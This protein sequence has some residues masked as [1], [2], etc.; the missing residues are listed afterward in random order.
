MARWPLWYFRYCSEPVWGAAIKTR[1][2]HFTQFAKTLNTWG[3]AA[4][5]AGLKFY[6]HNHDGEF[7]RF[8]GRPIFNILLEETDPELVYFELDL[9]WTA[10]A[11]EDVYEIVRLHQHRFPLFH[12]KDFRFVENGPRSAKPDTL[13]AG[14]TFAFTDVGKG[15]IDWA[16]LLGGLEDPA[17]HTYFIERDDAGSVTADADNATGPTNPAGPANTIWVSSQY[18]HN[19]TF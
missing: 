6:F 19:L 7:T 15:E 10:I 8:D 5:R 18:L 13:A 14:R 4:A 3:A 1:L 11:G 12:V 2:I 9:A 16:R 17:R